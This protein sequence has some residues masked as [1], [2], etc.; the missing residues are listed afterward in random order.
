MVDYGS[1]FDA[2][3]VGEIADRT[4]TEVH[5][6]TSVVFLPTCAMSQGQQGY[7]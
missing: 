7:S 5:C 1:V 3:K 2:G 4:V 6:K